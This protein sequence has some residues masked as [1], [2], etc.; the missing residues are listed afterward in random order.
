MPA[1]RGESLLFRSS[2][3]TVAA[4]V[5]LDLDDF[6]ADHGGGGRVGAVGRVGHQDL[7]AL[8][9][10]AIEVVGAEDQHAGELALR[11]GRRLQRDRVEAR[12]LGQQLL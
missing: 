12:D 2:R 11:A 10:A 1:V 3:S 4:A 7:R 9:V 8:G 6:H 5:A